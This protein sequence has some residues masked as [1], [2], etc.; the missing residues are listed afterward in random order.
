MEGLWNAS[1]LDFL[2]SNPVFLISL[3]TEASTM[4]LGDSISSS[5]LGSVNVTYVFLRQYL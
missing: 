5:V 4:G 1:S 3:L 2:C